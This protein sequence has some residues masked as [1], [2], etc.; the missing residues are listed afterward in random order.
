MS[1]V[2]GS[3]FIGLVLRRRLAPLVL[4][5]AVGCLVPSSSFGAAVAA[6]EVVSYT[7][8]N[9]REDYRNAAAALGLPAGDTTFGAL[10]PFNPPFSNQHIVI[11]G[12]GGELTL[13][14]ASPVAAGPGPELGVFVNN[15]LVDISPTGT[16]TAGRPPETFSPPP[17]ALVSVSADGQQFVP[18]A[19]GATVTFDNPTNAYTDTRIENYS[20]P[21]GTRPADFGKPF[22]G[23]LSDFAGETYEQMLTRLAGSAGGTWLDVSG[24]GLSSVQYV[25]F[26]VPQGRMVVDAVTAVPEP[27]ALGLMLLPALLFGRHRRT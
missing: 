4:A 14:L 21:L 2:H 17:T 19:G 25:R 10:T 23:T 20:A 13:R 22:T 27:A 8:G 7:P 12:A 6:S 16:G 26:E 15:G 24:T 18:L 5:G 1:T 9:A 11:V 3:E